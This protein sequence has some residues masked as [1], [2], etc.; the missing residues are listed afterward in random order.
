M[1][2]NPDKTG[3]EWWT[4]KRARAAALAAE[5]VLADA[6]I[7]RKVG[8][9]RSTLSEWKARPEFAAR[10]A[11]HVEALEAAVS[12]Y[13]IAKR[14]ERV[15]VLDDLQTRYLTLL[16]ERGE[17]MEGEVPGGGTGTMARQVKQIGAGDNATVITEYVVETGISHEI[18]ALQKQAAQELGQWS[19]KSTVE[20]AGGIRR[21]YV[22]VTEAGE[23][24]LTQ[25]DLEA[26]DAPDVEPA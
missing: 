1:A 15:K 6:E 2:T 12:R 23:S 3:Q 16:D 18:R 20:H 14:R 13:R 9:A 5:D 7:A 24:P 22:L 4:Q 11:E 26:L 8:V 17:A 21:E 25:D 10:V 19:E